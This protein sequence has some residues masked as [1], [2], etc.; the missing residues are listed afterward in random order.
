MKKGLAL[1][2][3][4]ALAAAVPAFSGDHKG[5][6][7]T[8]ATQECLDQMVS[9]LKNRGWTGIE[10]DDSKGPASFRVTRVV[11]GSPAEAAGFQPDDVLVSINGIRYS[12]GNMEK[13]K[14]AW[15]DT[16]PGQSVSYVVARGG[17]EKTLTV[18]LG[19]LP[20]DVMAQ[21]VGMHM[22]EHASTTVAE[23]AK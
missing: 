17:I 14:E 18:T 11:A 4:L 12:E 21:W 22:L 1:A 9:K 19:Q 7:C 16:K 23:A 10:F 2:L 20:S 5:Y 6:K 13:I 3:V 15:G 8:V